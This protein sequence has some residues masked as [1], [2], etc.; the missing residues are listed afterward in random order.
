MKETAVLT[1]KRHSPRV[2]I[3][4]HIRYR[5]IPIAMKGPRNAAVRDVGEG[6]FRFQS[7]EFMDR[8]SNMLL[9][10]YLPG[11]HI[12]RSLATV[13]WIK[14]LP[15]D[16]GYEVGGMFLEPTHETRTELAKIVSNH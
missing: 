16:D 2:A 5:R 1:E 9:E 11:T 4:G 3:E 14:A 8:K 12:I 13:A 7:A 10:L 15:G 6:G